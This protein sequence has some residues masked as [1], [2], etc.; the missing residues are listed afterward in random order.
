MSPHLSI[1]NNART[2]T[3]WYDFQNIPEALRKQLDTTD[4]LLLPSGYRNA[5]HAFAESTSLFLQWC[6]QKEYNIDIC[7]NDDE[8]E[9]VE[10]NS[11]CIR[12]GRINLKKAVGSIFFGLLINFIYDLGKGNVQSLMNND[13]D[14]VT[15]GEEKTVSFTLAVE[16]SKGTTKEYHYEGPVES[17]KEVT[18]EI[19]T[20]WNED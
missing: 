19:K 9:L 7:V 4:I 15:Q 2:R 6:Q 5:E 10:L 8:Y 11:S 1:N 12:L 13:S 14:I 18:E 17:V 20:L 3:D 16:D